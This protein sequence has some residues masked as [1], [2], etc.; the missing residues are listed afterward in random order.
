MDLVG[1]LH[2]VDMP[3]SGKC[4]LN[5]IYAVG[6]IMS[7]LI[8]FESVLY[9]PVHIDSAFLSGVQCSCIDKVVAGLLFPEC[10]LVS[11]FSYCVFSQYCYSIFTGTWCCSAFKYMDDHDV[12]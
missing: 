5:Y 12:D 8:H 9:E 2:M 4:D 7:I 11:S 3:S 1:L 6:L 10:W